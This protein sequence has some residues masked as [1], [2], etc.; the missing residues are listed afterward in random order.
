M[1]LH[2]F[3]E[4]GQR[5][6]PDLWYVLSQDIDPGGDDTPSQRVGH[7]MTYVPRPRLPP[8]EGREIIVKCT[9]NGI[10]LF[11]LEYM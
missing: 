8:N 9:S 3:L 10:D 7:T 2:P 4:P 11:K 1:E 6:T 5:L